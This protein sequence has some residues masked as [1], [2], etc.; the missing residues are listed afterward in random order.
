M[1]KNLQ[2]RRSTLAVTG[3]KCTITPKQDKTAFLP[4]RLNV[5]VKATVLLKYC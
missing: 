5:N 1:V 2:K 4:E 3:G